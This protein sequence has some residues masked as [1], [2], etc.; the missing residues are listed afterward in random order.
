MELRIQ[1][2]IQFLLEAGVRRLT[3]DRA[4]NGDAGAAA[5]ASNGSPENREFERR[6]LPARLTNQ[7]CGLRLAA[8]G[9]RLAACGLRLAACGF[10]VFVIAEM[11]SFFTKNISFVSSLALS[12]P[13][14]SAA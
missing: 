13:K 11:S 5:P 3:G 14:S 7:A 12:L 2:N 8:C 1:K 4:R 10:S 6:L 9:L